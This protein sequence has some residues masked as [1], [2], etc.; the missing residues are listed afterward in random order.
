MALKRF[1]VTGVMPIRDAKTRESVT[2]GGL[3]H[4][5]D[6]EVV[7][8]KG[9]PLAATDIEALIDA[10]CIEPAETAERGSAPAEKD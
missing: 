2:T 7:R 10:G 8:K 1:R 4:L 5:D 6:A 3:V 9:T